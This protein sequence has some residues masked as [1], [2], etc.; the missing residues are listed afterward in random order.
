VRSPHAALSP[1]IGPEFDDF[2]GASIGEDRNGT[3]LSV[4]LSRELNL[5]VR[6]LE[7]PVWLRP[8]WP[9]ARSGRR[10]HVIET[11]TRSRIGARNFKRL[12]RPRATCS[13]PQRVARGVIELT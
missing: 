4:A 12:R 8:P 1:L 7:V 13:S 2:L 11:T 10:C 9:R 5:V 6:E 3:G